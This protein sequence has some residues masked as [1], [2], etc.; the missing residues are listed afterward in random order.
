MPRELALF[1]VTYRDASGREYTRP[2]RAFNDAEA[3]Q[4]V[5]AEGHTVIRSRRVFWS[6]HIAR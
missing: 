3:R 5:T 6:Y 4:I 1:N 2:V